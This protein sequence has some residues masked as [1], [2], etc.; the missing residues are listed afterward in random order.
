[1]SR[2]TI[3]ILFLSICLAACTK[4]NETS[5]WRGPN[6][7]GI[8]NEKGLLKQWPA[9][10]PE[11]LW[12]YEGLGFGHSTVAVANDKIYV[13]GIKDTLE[14]QGTLFTFNLNGE[15]LWKRKYGK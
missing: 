7:N 3:L 8:F 2:V 13:T 12:S 10:G 11:M 5:D 6:R 14:S 15:L 9:E 1:M 4:N